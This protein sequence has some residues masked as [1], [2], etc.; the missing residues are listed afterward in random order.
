MSGALGIDLDQIW[1][2]A[3][4]AFRMLLDRMIE[5]LEAPEDR[6]AVED[7][8]I[9][10]RLN[11]SSYDEAQARRLAQAMANASHQLSIHLKETSDDSRDQ[12][13]SKRLAEIEGKLRVLYPDLDPSPTS[14]LT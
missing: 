3:G 9:Y 6:E 8:K 10:Q 2:F 12:G 4:W 5:L 11:L 7:G 13:F 14:E 1:I